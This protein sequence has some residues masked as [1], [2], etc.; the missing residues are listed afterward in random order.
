M[1]GD[2]KYVFCEPKAAVQQWQVLGQCQWV[3][4]VIKPGRRHR[5]VRGAE[6][7][8]KGLRWKAAKDPPRA[9]GEP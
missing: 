5:A 8:V 4:D 6:H 1:A 3:R 9:G 2:L 7:S